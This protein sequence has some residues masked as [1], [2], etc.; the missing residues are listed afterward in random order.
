MRSIGVGL[1]NSLIDKFAILKFAELGEH[2]T[3]YKPA[4]FNIVVIFLQLWVRAAVT[5]SN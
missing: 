4:L 2:Y 3:T 1:C 5:K